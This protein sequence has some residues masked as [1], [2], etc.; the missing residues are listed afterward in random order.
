MA[1][2]FKRGTLAT[3]TAIS[4]LIATLSYGGDY[5]GQD[6]RYGYRRHHVDV[7]PVMN[8]AYIKECGSCHFAYQPGWLPARSWQ[9]IM[10]TLDDHFGDNAELD[11][12]TH[13]QLLDYLVSNAGDYG[14]SQ[15]AARFRRVIS[16]EATPLRITEAT[17]F[18]RKHYEIPPQ[19]VRNNREIGSFSNCKAC[20]TRAET[21]SFNE[22]EIRI[23]GLRRRDD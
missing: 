19:M 6:D 2:I 10:S 22:H 7:P 15:R 20:H 14:N 1:E 23:P 17:Y 18:R 21:G 5:G 11:P 8:E 4:G 16:P 12:E 13:E 3:V 9:A